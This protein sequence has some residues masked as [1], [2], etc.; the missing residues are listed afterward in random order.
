MDSK[1]SRTSVFLCVSLNMFVQNQS[2]LFRIPETVDLR[3]SHWNAE[4]FAHGAQGSMPSNIALKRPSTVAML[5]S[6]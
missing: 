4:N 5:A 6:S 1:Y 3:L 2:R